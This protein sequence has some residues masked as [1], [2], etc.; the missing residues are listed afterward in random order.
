[1]MSQFRILVGE[2]M[3]EYSDEPL[4]AVYTILYVFICTLVRGHTAIDWIAWGF[5]LG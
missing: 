3:P 1:M 4:L 2:S 5:N